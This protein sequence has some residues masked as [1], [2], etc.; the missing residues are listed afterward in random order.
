VIIIY[1]LFIFPGLS[2]ILTYIDVYTVV[3]FYEKGG[4]HIK[5]GVLV[6]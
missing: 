4:V 1:I 3:L 2:K 5:S 6:L